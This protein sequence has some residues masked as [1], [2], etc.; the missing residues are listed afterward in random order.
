MGELDDGTSDTCRYCNSTYTPINFLAPHGV[1]APQPF[2]GRFRFRQEDKKLI[3][4]L[5]TEKRDP[6]STFVYVRDE[7][8]DATLEDLTD[9][10]LY[11]FLGGV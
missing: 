5:Q 6:R 10:S 8:R 9:I 2:T 3:L 1:R 7:W 11:H 4:Q